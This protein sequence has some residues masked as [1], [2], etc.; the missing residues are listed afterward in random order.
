MQ[1]WGKSE[2]N[3]HWSGRQFFCSLLQQDSCNGIWTF[4]CVL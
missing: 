3:C 4:N 2:E 1:I